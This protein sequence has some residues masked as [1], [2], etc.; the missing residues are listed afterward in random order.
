LG[1]VNESGV[2]VTVSFKTISGSLQDVKNKVQARKEI[3]K[4]LKNL[5]IIVLKIF[6]I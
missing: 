4:E 3:R 6:Y 2:I 5:I 1:I